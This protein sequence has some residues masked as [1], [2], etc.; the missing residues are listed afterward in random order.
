MQQAGHNQVKRSAHL[1][2]S[3]RTECVGK[4]REG[5]DACY[6]GTVKGACTV[7]IQGFDFEMS[8]TALCFEFS[9]P[10]L[11]HYFGDCGSGVW[12]A[13]PL[14][15]RLALTPTSASWFFTT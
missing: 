8:P 13:Q 14:G 2:P 6:Q 3:I 1:A 10:S 11:W 4:Y 7:C 15:A 9:V 5:A 12:L